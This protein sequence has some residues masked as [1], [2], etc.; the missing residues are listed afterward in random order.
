MI[1]SSKSYSLVFD[2]HDFSWSEVI[3]GFFVL[4]GVHLTT[5]Y[6][7]LL[8][9]NLAELFSVIIAI[10][11]FI[12]AIN[13]WQSIQNQYLL[14]IGVAYLFIGFIDILHTLSYK[15][16]GVFKDYDYY[17]PQFWIAARAMES[18]SMVIGL[19]FLSN[20]KK[21]SR[22]FLLIVFLI[23]TTL[24][25]SSIVYFKIFPECFVP[26]QG[27]TPFK[28]IMEYL[29]SGMLLLSLVM[30]IQRKQFFDERVLRLVVWSIAVTI[31]MEMCFTQ[32]KSVGMNDAMNQIGHL[33]K[34]VAFYFIYKAVVVTGLTDPINLLFRK[35]KDNEAALL[36]AQQLARLGRWDWNPSTDEC[37]FSREVLQFFDLPDKRAYSLND[38]FVRM[39]IQDRQAVEEAMRRLQQGGEPFELKV[40]ISHSEC[41]RFAQLRGAGVRDDAGLVIRVSGTLQDISDE[42]RLQEVLSVAKDKEKFELL[43]QTAGDGIHLLDAGGNVVEVNNMFCHMLGYSRDELLKMNVAQWDANF[44]LQALAEKLKE[45]FAAG[46][47]FETRHRRKNGTIIDVEISAKAVNYGGVPVLWNAS[48]DIAERKNAE[49]R[50]KRTNAELEQFSY[51]V[52]HDMRQPLRM[53]SSYLQLLEIELGGSLDDE[54]R[55]YFNYAVDGAKRIDCMLEALL[56]YSRIGRSA[57]P[58][59]PVDCRGALDEAMKYLQPDILDAQADVSIAGAWPK[60]FASRD[61]LVRLF[62]NL[63][64]NAVKYRVAGRA[65]KISVTSKIDTDEWTLCIEDNGVGIN[66]EQIN[67]L[68][69]V[70]QRLQTRDD[71]EGTG[72][73]LA[74]CRKIVEH[75][76]GEIW[77]ESGGEGQGSRFCVKLPVNHP[78]DT[79]L[80]GFTV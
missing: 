6:N 37:Q 34:I 70:F 71:Y 1:Q 5:Y 13:C 55:S 60:L 19:Y 54:K 61:E 18:I 11:I 28:K 40:R 26:G 42:Q 66:P 20:G 67:R 57:D 21:L 64:G 15:G 46:N 32:Y 29:I 14:F 63:I 43:M 8:F 47:I 38:V 56:D 24:L 30:L 45:N 12:I 80:S 69:K 23:A 68:F 36:Q 22:N 72:I 3:I 74:L 76:H 39:Q 10:T 35:L 44:S 53:I 9:H 65:V 59:I 79:S 16:M 7:Y 4:F 77:A 49:E 27:L 31:L 17:A 52:S 58:F 73:G 41:P 2:R 48:R 78:V 75:H 25:V 51:A 33:L 62:Q 50:L